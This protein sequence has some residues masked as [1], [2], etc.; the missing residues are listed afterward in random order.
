MTQ[1]TEV[2]WQIGQPGGKG[3]GFVQAG[4][5][6]PEFTYTVDDDANAATRPSMPPVLIDPARKTRMKRGGK[7]AFSTAK[8]NIRFTLN[9]RYQ[10]KELVLF[11]DFY[12]AETDTLRVDGK[13]IKTLPGAG[14]GKLKKNQIPLPALEAGTHTLTL[15]T[16][17]ATRDK[18]HW[19]DS[20]KLTGVVVPEVVKDPSPQAS[21]PSTAAPN[22]QSSSKSTSDTMAK[23]KAATP[24]PA[25][26][27]AETKSYIPTSMTG[28]QD[29][30]YWWK[31]A[32][33]QAKTSGKGKETFRRGR[34]WA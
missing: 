7:V 33:E 9:H 4:G 25:P 3:R 22:A 21:A 11:Y 34:I 10:A 30:S 28:L 32:R 6:H 12:G 15:T 8:L 23:K 1:T 17:G 26:A 18:A 16:K 5:W 31:Y 14:E 27:V 2:L 29:Y 24:A 19:I 20:L 13:Q